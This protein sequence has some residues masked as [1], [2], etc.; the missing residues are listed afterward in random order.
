MGEEVRFSSVVSHSVSLCPSIAEK[1]CDF[2]QLG[3]KAIF[4]LEIYYKIVYLRKLIVRKNA[5]YLSYYSI[6]C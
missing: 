3:I 4:I 1:N 5:I 6:K 2:I